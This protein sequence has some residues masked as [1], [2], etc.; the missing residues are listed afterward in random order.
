MPVGEPAA[1]GLGQQS[2][3]R[4]MG[5]GLVEAGL[6]EQAFLAGDRIGSRVDL[7][8]ERATRQLLY[9]TFCWS[10]L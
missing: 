2:A 5:G 6:P 4:Y 3:Q 1:V 8:S 9:V 7:D 10:W